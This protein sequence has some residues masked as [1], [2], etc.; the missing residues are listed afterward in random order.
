MAEIKLQE[1]FRQFLR[2]N[3]KYPPDSLLAEAA[4]SG[5][6]RRLFAD[7]LLIDTRYQEYIGIVE[8][9]MRSDRQT[10]ANAREQVHSYLEAL[11]MPGLPAYLVF[12]SGENDFVIHVLTE[13]DWQPIEKNEFP[14]F[15]TLAAKKKIDE[16]TIERDVQESLAEAARRYQDRTKRLSIW[17]VGSLMIGVVAAIISSIFSLYQPGRNFINGCDCERIDSLAVIV[18]SIQR[19]LMDTTGRDPIAQRDTSQAYLDLKERVA[20]IDSLLAASTDHALMLAGVNGDI[21][22]LHAELQGQENVL[23]VRH[24]NMLDRLDLLFSLVVGVILAMFSI[25]IG[26]FFTEYTDRRRARANATTRST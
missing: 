21:K 25:V 19:T 2:R 16:K 5:G 11:G 22:V 12:P 8:F 9:K 18:G 23:N 20:A 26:F 7:L 14:D 1:Q 15:E 3:K 4:I 6:K 24:Q 10:L 17:A 13:N